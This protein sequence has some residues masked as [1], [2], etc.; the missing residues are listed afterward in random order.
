MAENLRIDHVIFGTHDIETTAELLE[1]RHGLGSV[2]GGRHEGLGTGNRIVPVGGAYIELMGIVDAEE[3]AA[4]PFGRWFADQIADGD[5]LLMWCIG[6]DDIDAVAERLALDIEEWTRATPDGH[7]LSWRLAGLE[8]ANEHP[9]IPFFIQ[10]TVP[11]EMHPSRA[12]VAHRSRVKGFA[13]VQVVGDEQRVHEWLGG[14]ELPVRYGT[15]PA[16]IDAVTLA[17]DEGEISLP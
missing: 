15:G 13:E 10:W 5:R 2:V 6:T 7:T 1:E 14:A 9:E 12:D 8:I 17:T 3:A 16:G 4:H 11:P